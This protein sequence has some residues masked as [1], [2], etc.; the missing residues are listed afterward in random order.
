MALAQLLRQ[1]GVGSDA[2]IL[3]LPRGGVIVAEEVARE[4]GAVMDVFVVR[5]LGVPGHEELA[6][7]AIASGGIRV[8]ND[9]V[10]AELGIDSRTIELVAEAERAEL[11]RRDRLYRAGAPAPNVAGREVVVVDDGLATGATMLAAV[12][13]LRLLGP[14]RI[15]AAAPVAAT[16]ACA[17]LRAVADA[18]V[19]VIEPRPFLGVGAWYDDFAQTS[20]EEVRQSLQRAAG[21]PAPDSR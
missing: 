9:D 19:A 16:E 21:A 8:F 2:L 18:C 11:E 5:K 14:A 3:G 12:K 20:D 7:G 4:L 6:M 15:I 13:A 17:T 10:I 1:E